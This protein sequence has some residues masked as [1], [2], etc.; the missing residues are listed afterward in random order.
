VEWG[1]GHNRQF[2]FG[3]PRIVRRLWRERD[4]EEDWMQP[5]PECYEAINENPRKALP[6]PVDSHWRSNARRKD[7]PGLA[8][9]TATK[10]AVVTAAPAPTPAESNVRIVVAGIV[11]VTGID[12]TRVGVA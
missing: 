1:R 6:L 5:I 9:E 7:A 4:P 11:S 2:S 8:A 10:A 3:G 12:V